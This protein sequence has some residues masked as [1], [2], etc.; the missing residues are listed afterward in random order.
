MKRKLTQRLG[1]LTIAMLVAILAAPADALIMNADIAS[2]AGITYGKLKLGGK[3]DSDD[4][5]NG[6]IQ[7]KDIKNGTISGS[8][9][10]DD[11]IDSDKIED[12][13]ITVADLAAGTLT[14]ASLADSAVTSAKILDSTVASA[15]IAADTIVAADI[16]TGGVGTLEILDGAILT[17]DIATDT[18][19]AADIAAGAV[20]TSEILDG[21]ITA[22]DIAAATI[23]N[24]EIAVDTILADSIAAGAVATSEILDE[25][26]ASADILNGTIAAADLATDLIITTTGL[27]N[28][29]GGI[30]VD[31][32]NFTVSGTTGAV[33]SASTITGTALYTSG[34]TID[35]T[36]A[37]TVLHIGETFATGGI[38][39]DQVATVDGLLTAGAGATI[40][41]DLKATPQSAAGTAAEGVVYYDS[42]DD[43][44]YV[45][46]NGGWVDM[47]AGASGADTLDTAYNTSAGAST[48][49][50]DNGDLTLRSNAAATGDIIVDLNSTS[51]FILQDAGTDVITFSDTGNLTMASGTLALNNDAVASDGDLT[52]TG[53]TGLNATA[54][55]GDL[56]IT[57]TAG[58]IIL[59][60]GEN[61]SDSIQIISSIGGIDITAAAATA[62]DI[63]ILNTGG[64][65]N[66]VATE[67]AADAIV[68]SA[69]TALG[70][71]D[72][73]SN[74]DVDITTTG[75]ADEDISL[76]NTG[77]S[78]NI[79]ATEGAADAIV[80]N[81]S[82]ALGGIDITSNADVDITTTGADGEDI[83]LTN[84]GGS[85]NITATEAA[86]D[87]I[88]I[89]AST[90]L[91]GIDITSN[92]DIDITTTGAAGEDISLTNT[93]GSVNITASESATDAIV[94][95]ASAGG[96]NIAATG[97]ATEDITLVNTGGSVGI[98]A[99]EAAADAIVLNASTALGGIDITSNADVD[100][101]TTGADGEDISLTN[102][103]G[104]VNIT[105]TEAATDAIVI[106]AS[107][108]LGGID[109]T[110]NEDIDITTTGAAGEDIS[111]T[112]TGGSVNITA[113]EA[114]ADAIVLSASTAAGGI[115]ITSNA[116]VDITT[117]GAAGEDITIDN[118]GG[119]VNISSSESVADA[120]VLS[121][122]AG[123]IDILSTSGTDG[124]DINITSTGI[125]GEIR[126]ATASTEADAVR[127][128]ASAGGIDIDADGN[129][130]AITGTADAAGEDVSLIQDGAV[131][132]SVVL[133]S[134]GTGVDAIDMTASAGGIDI[135]SALAMDIDTA[136]GNIVIDS[137]DAGAGAI[138]AEDDGEDDLGTDATRWATIFADTL[139]YRTALTDD[140]SDNTTVTM[141]D[142]VTLDTVNVTANTA[143]T[144]GQWSVTNLGVATFVSVD[145]PLGSVTP[146]AI[147]A[148]TIQLDAVLTFDTNNDSVNNSADATFDFTRDDTG[149]VT[150]TAS[151]DDANAAMLIVAG[152]TGDMTL[153]DADSDT[154]VA[155]V[156]A[157]NGATTIGD[158]GDNV[159]INSDVWDI[160]AA[161]AATGLTGIVSSGTISFTGSTIGF[162]DNEAD[163]ITLTGDTTIGAGASNNVIVNSNTWDVSAAG[164]ASGLTGV[165]STG[166][167][168]FSG[169][170]LEVPNGTDLP[171]T[172][173]VGMIFHE[174]DDDACADAAGGD[175]ALCICKSANTWAAV[176]NF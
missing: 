40:V 118:A 70:G 33:S 146:A 174:T 158:G 74:A 103:G 10:D 81:A 76:T 13:S 154:T 144:D 131:D 73:T 107:T 121:A 166:T 140:A 151:D 68:L 128:A 43:N 119:S 169:A 88:V 96:I 145:G 6:S 23:T 24:S 41:G 147:D 135:D 50:V 9:I 34:G 115:D 155:G 31:T 26:V 51:D 106:S 17:G 167:V 125:T 69:S 139:N 138:V 152:G 163:A 102:T 110:S 52:I 3:I 12:G 86:T 95:T 38:I 120:I 172:C 67:A 65:V 117:T 171:A 168:D 130:I 141:G 149:T 134:A 28:L 159:A 66:I 123:G 129:A 116:D 63:D 92:E 47:T 124:E 53:A 2:N 150:I 54:T 71:I 78:V 153:G 98:T 173:S 122:T 46:A 91:G 48:V 175:G 21:T 59:T 127:I 4:I 8:K 83:S 84:T 114:A 57:S 162:G 165:T 108:A 72:I 64:S 27:A 60:A 93:G 126:L 99:T 104:S 143:I 94:M 136:A 90:A 7:G 148:T 80:L 164:V 56:D 49:L 29:N 170:T 111:L 176:A 75:A 5:K 137:V 109:I 18:I 35:A 19:L 160:N 11:A 30:A 156:L 58:S 62:E 1:V 15:D 25:S 16:A 44:L 45:Y 20:A 37:G 85:V 79:T 157:A 77:G 22:D 32:S 61:A 36:I 100:I 87:A 39:L 14:A 89:S 132:A 97:A 82:T 55:T 161:G 105:A 113:S 101:T 133:T 142:S 112:N 42:D